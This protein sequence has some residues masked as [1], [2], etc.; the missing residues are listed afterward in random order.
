M[1]E[2]PFKPRAD[3]PQTG[4]VMPWHLCQRGLFEAKDSNGNTALMLAAYN[5]KIE[6][7]EMLLAKGADIEA[8]DN[9]GYAAHDY[10]STMYLGK[11]TPEILARLLRTPPCPKPEATAL[12]PQTP[13]HPRRLPQP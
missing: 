10:A 7:A 13:R 11:F 5:G 9:G 6:T 1:K 2:D 3:L 12:N 4:L 8:K